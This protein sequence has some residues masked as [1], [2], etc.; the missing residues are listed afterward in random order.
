MRILWIIL[1]G[2][3]FVLS[4]A[5]LIYTTW[6]TASDFSEHHYTEHH[7]EELREKL[8]KEKEVK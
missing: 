1:W 2:G 6:T 4:I 3:A 8:R 7:Y 5:F